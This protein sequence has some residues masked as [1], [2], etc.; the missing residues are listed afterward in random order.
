VDALPGVIRKVDEFYDRDWAHR[1]TIALDSDVTL[2]LSPA[3][4]CAN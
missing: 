1:Q 2:L 4:F 3:G